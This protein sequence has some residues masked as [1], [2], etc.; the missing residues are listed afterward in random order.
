MFICCVCVVC[1]QVEV[2]ATSRS[3]VQ[4]SPTDC[5]ASLCVIKKPRGSRGHCPP[6]AAELEKIINTR[7]NNVGNVLLW[8][9][10]R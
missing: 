9:I 3:L 5:G 1:C 6:W 10:Y 2:L 4:K 8:V 7:N